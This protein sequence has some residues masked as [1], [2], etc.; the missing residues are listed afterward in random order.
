[1]REAFVVQ[2]QSATAALLAAPAT[3][4]GI[5]P[6]QIDTHGAMVFLAGERVYKVKRAV[7]F[8]FM[9]FSTLEKRHAALVEEY[10]VNH[11]TAPR[12]IWA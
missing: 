7:H 8:P 3:H 2:D 11:R 9:D 6:Q 10:R 4:A 5:V 12:C 1:M